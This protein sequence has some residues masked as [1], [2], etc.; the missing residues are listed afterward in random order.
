MLTCRQERSEAGYQ[1]L[2]SVAS[3]ILP[4]LDHLIFLNR[5]WEV[6]QI[7]LI[8]KEKEHIINQVLSAYD[9]IGICREDQSLENVL[10]A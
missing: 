7:K 3:V 8:T 10:S 9:S 4:V 2:K 1:F 6:C 5:S